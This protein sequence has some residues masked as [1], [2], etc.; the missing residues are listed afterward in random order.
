MPVTN[1][2]FSS[3]PSDFQKVF[4]STGNGRLPSCALKSAD[5]LQAG[6]T[7]H[8]QA[9]EQL[10]KLMTAAAAA[11]KSFRVSSAYRT[12][13]QQVALVGGDPRGTRRGVASPG[14]S[15]HGWGTAI[16]ISQL[17]QL[18]MQVAATFNTQRRGG[19]SNWNHFDP[20]VHT[21]VRETSELFKWLDENAPKYGWVNPDWARNGGSFDECWHWEYKVF[22]ANWPNTLPPSI[23]NKPKT[24]PITAP[25]GSL[26]STREYYART[27]TGATPI[28]PSVSPYLST[29]ESFHPNI[30]YELTR[31]RVAS[32]TTNVYMPFVR[33]TSLIKVYGENLEGGSGKIPQGYC[34]SL[35]PHGQDYIEFNEIYYPKNNRSLV[36]FATTE[37]SVSE[38]TVVKPRTA[39]IVSEEDS[40]YDQQSIPMPGIIDMTLDRST[41]GPMGVRGGLM[42]ADIK[43]LA[44][45]VGQLNTLLLYFLRPATRVVLEMGRQSSN[46]EEQITPWNWNT[47]ES[48]I[49]TQFTNI[50]YDPVAQRK[51]IEDYVYKNNGNYEI[52]VG[53]V[54]KFDLKYTKNNIYE[55]LLTVHS[56]QQFE[57]PTI[58]TGVRSNC[59]NAIDKC[60]V[61]DIREY[62]NTDASWKDN[63]FKQLMAEE[64][65]KANPEGR[66]AEQQRATRG[67]SDHFI[68]IRNPAPGD[69]GAGSR[70]AGLDENE[71]FVSWAF[72]VERILNDPTRG[73]A[74][75]IPDVPVST[76]TTAQP[77]TATS[78]SSQP[79]SPADI[80]RMSPRELL[81]LG[82]LRAVSPITKTTEIDEQIRS[83]LIA[84]EV[85]Y[86]PNLRST[87]PNVMIIYN[88]VAQDNLG[89]DEKQ[90]FKSLT[91]A[92]IV[93]D[94]QRTEFTSNEYLAKF[95]RESSVGA[96]SKVVSTDPSQASSGYLNNGIWLNTRA[97]KE[98][99]STADTVSSAINILLGKMNAA[100]EGYW[101]LQLYSA[102]RTHSGL[103]VVDMGLSKRLDNTTTT[104]GQPQ[105][106]FLMPD[107]EESE[108]NP[109]N[110]ITA[111]TKGRYA[112]NPD[113]PSS[114]SRYIYKF[115]RG[116]RTL[117]DGQHIGSDLIDLN[118]QFNLPQVIAV[119]AIA[120]VGGSSQKGVWESIKIEELTKLN[121][122]PDLYAPCDS[123]SICVGEDCNRRIDDLTALETTW[124]NA[125]AAA[126]AS[127]DPIIE[128]LAGETAQQ[129]ADRV[130]RETQERERLRQEAE[131]ARANY[132]TAKIQR[133]FGNSMV[134]STFAEL[135]SLG[136]LLEFIEFN[137]SVMMKK[138]NKDS[139]NVEENRIEPYAHAF[140]SSNLTKTT[141]KLTLP[142]IGGIELWQSFLVDRAPSILDKGYYVVTKVTHKFSSQ[143]GWTT[144]IEGRFRYRPLPQ[145]N[146]APT[147]Y[148]PNCVE[149]RSSA[150]PALPP[151]SQPRR[152]GAGPTTPLGG[153]R[154]P[155]EQF[156]QQLPNMTNQQ[157]YETFIRYE[158][159]AIEPSFPSIAERE[160]WERKKISGQADLA[161]RRIEKVK[162]EIKKRINV[163]LRAGTGWPQEFRSLTERRLNPRNWGPPLA[164]NAPFRGAGSSG[165]F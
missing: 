151:A 102:D 9:A 66:T 80:T 33:L 61:A 19:K 3:I 15:M 139:R 11:G 59:S 106:N 152:T 16:D 32:E 83:G 51:F 157:L 109:L 99:F 142:G 153:A 13:D 150:A 28:P 42:K 126:A 101:N 78:S 121:L 67:Y 155:D 53:Y 4:T 10:G 90:N 128:P 34:P 134:I 146:T 93:D 156:D 7:I 76:S 154:N 140:N 22:S 43:I 136:T 12:Y 41:A 123:G 77:G 89:T 111:I 104:N 36:G 119:Q 49:S 74:S 132:Q 73:I 50:L 161:R 5:G 158:E 137:P 138:L 70:A 39:L 114:G 116:T 118:I 48:Y 162:I 72:F 105:S 79:T 84:N 145:T 164:S 141:V 63:S 87:D 100:T 52:F 149:V 54:V 65:A 95:I 58:H 44:Y 108:S 60:K 46:P 113:V 144:E 112:K 122:I 81:K 133:S 14:N 47:Q 56:V 37:E 110:S 107:M 2:N 57:I 159:S 96:F 94:T 82:M 18:S 29:L 1:N 75:I 127:P 85:G 31:R 30:Q 6:L 21:Y 62:F 91:E 25:C 120:G 55:I 135:S 124:N 165:I 69:G 143:N 103:F 71:Y 24:T 131:Q 35:G 68:A 8:P 160:A 17:F 125:K 129:T 115:N 20:E 86:H 45:S 117:D 148:N 147:D 40:N 38:A 163:G 23:T 27:A 88:A 92:A 64:E 26:T 97:I 98:A 130:T